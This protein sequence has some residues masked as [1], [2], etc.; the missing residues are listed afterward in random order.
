M[1][2]KICI[3]YYKS[4]YQNHIQQKKK[5]VK[6]QEKKSLNKASTRTRI[7]YYADFTITTQAYIITK[8]KNS[9][10]KSIQHARTEG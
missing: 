3:Y 7:S 2:D 8:I 1:K 5:K 4:Q 9:N 6:M 10:G